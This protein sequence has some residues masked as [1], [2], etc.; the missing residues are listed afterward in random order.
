MN[1]SAVVEW[2]DD[3]NAHIV[4][5]FSDDLVFSLA[6]EPGVYKVEARLKKNHN[7]IQCGY[8]YQS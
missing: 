4:K 8:F 6:N 5:T 1:K 2:F 3:D 7:I